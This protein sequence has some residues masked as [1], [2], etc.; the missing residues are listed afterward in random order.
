MNAA[1]NEDVALQTHIRNIL[2]DYAVQHLTYNYLDFTEQAV[3][4]ILSQCLRQA[5]LS[6]SY[7]LRLPEEPFEAL[8]R[9]HKLGALSH[10]EET[11]TMSP[12][13]HQLFRCQYQKIFAK[14]SKSKSERVIYDDNYDCHFPEEH[15]PKALSRHARQQTPKRGTNTLLSPLPTRPCDLLLLKSIGLKHVS[16]YHGESELV[17]QDKILDASWTLDSD[18]L[19]DVNEFLKSTAA[20]SYPGAAYKNLYLEPS[21]REHSPPPENKWSLDREFTPIFSRSS[22]PGTRKALADDAS[23]GGNTSVNPKSDCSPPSFKVPVSM[24]D[25]ATLPANVKVLKE[26]EDEMYKENLLLVNGWETYNY[27]SSPSRGTPAS[28]P[29]SSQGSG[30]IDELFSRLSSPETDPS[31][32]DFPKMDLPAI[33]RCHQVTGARSRAKIRPHGAGKSLAAFLLNSLPPPGE[34]HVPIAR[35]HQNG[36]NERADSIVG[37]ATSSIL[38]TLEKGPDTC[39][40]ESDLQ[41]L[42][43]HLLVDPMG[44]ILNEK[45]EHNA[46]LMD[47]PRLPPPNEHSTKD[48]PLPMKLSDLVKGKKVKAQLPSPKANDPKKYGPQILKKAKGTQAATLILSWVTFSVQGR[49]PTHMEMLGVTASQ[50]IDRDD[51]K[52]CLSQAQLENGVAELL[53]SLDTLTCSPDAGDTLEVFERFAEDT[54]TEDSSFMHGGPD[55][56]ASDIILT[57]EERRRLAELDTSGLMEVDRCPKFIGEENNETQNLSQQR[58]IRNHIRVSLQERDDEE[59]EEGSSD[60]ENED[61]MQY[62]D[63]SQESE[64]P[65]KRTRLDKVLKNVDDSGIAFSL[66]EDLWSVA[67]GGMEK[68]MKEHCPDS[69][70]RFLYDA[71]QDEKPATIWGLEE[72]GKLAENDDYRTDGNQVPVDLGLYSRDEG[73]RKSPYLLQDDDFRPLC[74]DSQPVGQEIPDEANSEQSPP[75]SATLLLDYEAT[76]ASVLIPSRLPDCPPPNLPLSANNDVEHLHV[77]AGIAEFAKLRAKRLRNDPPSPILEPVKTKQSSPSRDPAYFNHECQ[78]AD[79]PSYSD[80]SPPLDL[81]SQNTIQLPS[82][83]I[84]PTSAHWYLASMQLVQ[85]QT[86]VRYLRSESCGV[87]IVEREDLNGVDLILD[88]HTAVIYINLRALPSQCE[89]IVATLSEQSWRYTRLF[90]VFEAYPPSWSFKPIASERGDSEALNVYTPPVI[91]AI[92]KLRRDLSISEGCNNKRS[93]C[94]IFEAFARDVEAAAVH[95]RNFGDIVASDGNSNPILWGDRDWLEGDVSEDEAGLAVADGMNHFAAVVILCQVGVQD[96]LD[97]QP[98]DRISSFGPYVGNERMQ[99]LN[100]FIESRLQVL[101]DTDDQPR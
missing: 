68:K 11:S 49:L 23:E 15:L 55:L 59:P 50:L 1:R 63:H 10:Y 12:D 70:D 43:G 52:N 48:M 101:N 88:P 54:R 82:S 47:V 64:R 18:L 45:L 30:Q 100:S 39:A 19:K 3:T 58:N 29:G 22:R 85:K 93:S 74:F 77:A 28:T 36:D 16:N 46:M 94:K 35:E 20:L 31:S 78:N 60:K 96:V 6:D 33:A 86:L 25:I 92:K 27:S 40:E 26:E 53:G 72:I 21:A 34:L 65:T 38:A 75:P 2:R 84:P 97:M 79:V 80:S 98:E 61:P 4:E 69:L 24:R 32:V 81:L 37:Q 42:Y 91:K 41:D 44:F 89:S 66:P 14:V 62:R 71:T 76:S 95:I 7:S 51:L 83:W 9:T 8:S 87:G 5:P 57:R 56:Y 90:V 17:D 99:T 73:S 13:V 67:S